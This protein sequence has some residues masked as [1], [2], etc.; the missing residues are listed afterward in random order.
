M[1]AMT[2]FILCLAAATM[3]LI[4][5]CKDSVSPDLDP[6]QE[7]LSDARLTIT[8][9]EL[10]LEA[11]VT[12]MDQA[13]GL[14][15]TVVPPGSLAKRTAPF[16]LR[17][18][19]EVSPP[20]S[21]GSTLQATHI[22]RDGDYVYVSYNTQGSTYLGGVDVFDVSNKSRPKLISR[23][24]FQNTDVSSVYYHN[25][26]SND[27]L[28]LAEATDDTSFLYPAVVEEITLNKHK[29]TLTSRRKGVSSYVATDVLVAS[30]KL[31]VSSG[32]GGAGIGG[33]TVLNLT[34][35][36]EITSDQFLD[37]RA[38]SNYGSVVAVMQGTPARLRTYNSSSNAFVTEYL[39]GGANI[40]ESK[41][42]AIVILSR[43]FVAAG[44]E[45]LKVVNM[46]TGVVVDSLPR[47]TVVG[48]DPSLTVTNSASV[49]DE[50]VFMANGEAGVYVAEAA[51]NLESS[52]SASSATNLKLLGKM[53][54]G[55]AQSANFVASR[56]DLL[57]IATGLGG[58]K[59]VEIN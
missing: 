56:G 2:I 48:I 32:S 17:L 6:S 22:A 18:R 27:K 33:L 29:L 13:V 44:D 20:Q 24:I 7:N 12:Y 15:T 4:P 21:G 58:L 51:V 34:T 40:A 30:S 31:F 10:Q 45:G 46:N 28:Y 3:F 37:A 23:A 1:K 5:G 14:D 57:F 54:F 41:S 38:V 39:V 9:N 47:V 42:T 50:L 52:G 16:S 55:T 43:A 11:Q 59:V 8:N 35:L 26:G 19:A 36:N 53:Q 25:S 49:N